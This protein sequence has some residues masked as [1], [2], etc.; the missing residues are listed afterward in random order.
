LESGFAA[1][2]GIMAMGSGAITTTGGAGGE[3]T[4]RVQAEASKPSTA[5]R[6][7]REKLLD[8]GAIGPHL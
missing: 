6:T 4:V 1:G 2:R 3:I 8:A 5:E 7:I